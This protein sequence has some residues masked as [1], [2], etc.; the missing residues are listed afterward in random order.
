[1]TPAI[2]LLKK[3]NIAHVVHEYVHEPLNVSYGLEAAEKLGIAPQ[4]VFKTL[5]V[6][7]DNKT[8]AVAVLPVSRQLNMKQV[9][10]ALGVKKAAMAAQVEVER[11]TGYVLGGVSPVGQKKLVATI[12]DDSALQFAT[13]YVSAGRRGLELELTP[14]DLRAVTV[15][16]FA[17]LV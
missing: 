7:L 3:Q 8:L 1:M 2:N 11:S 13:I 16:T 12:I 14:S 6:V 4:Q 15:A 17:K 10:K 9:A 5:V